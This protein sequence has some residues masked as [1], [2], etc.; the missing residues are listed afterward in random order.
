M[1]RRGRGTAGGLGQSLA[2][3]A[4]ILPVLLLL[5]LV[6]ID[7][8]RVYLGWVNLQNMARVAANFAANH[9]TSWVLNDA[10]DKADYQAQILADARAINCSLPMVGGV[11]TAP[12]PTFSPDT[13]LGSSATVQL[14][15]SFRVITPLISGII[16]NGG[17]VQVAASSTF[18][19][20]D[21]AFADG[22]GST[23]TAPVA[24]FTGSPTTISDGGTVA[25][26]DTSTGGPT[27]WSWTF[28]DGGTS[29]IQHPSHQY[30]LTDPNVSQ[31]FTVV[32]TATNSIGSDTRT[33]AAYIT[34]SPAPPT[35]DFTASNTAPNRNQS[36]TF[37]GTSTG[38]PTAVSWSFGD[39][40]T[41]TA[42]L[43]VNHA[44]ANAGTYTVSL[45]VTTSTGS[46]TR[47]RT[48]YITVSVGVCT[49]PSFI[50]TST[51]SGGATA[52]NTWN[53]AG[54]TT[55]MNFQQGGMPW[56]IRSQ[57]LT[58]NTSVPC[59]SSITV[60]RN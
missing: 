53:L 17:T 47:T 23:P 22:S 3:F 50:G 48:N 44:Y 33:K 7:F 32:L 42:G 18:P 10:E 60:S 40:Q 8:G 16:G 28:G 1:H 52:Q 58:G 19:I 46:A 31:T 35:V 59:N 6:A 13:N 41:S 11:A 55:T 20:K 12:D 4:L 38:T 45:T 5:T 2:E 26:T 51:G 21:G 39:G 43:V 34:V 49:V 29:T 15:C 30:V 56:T 24:N 57:S 25:F 27:S 36:I 54:F 37:T 9:P 14:S